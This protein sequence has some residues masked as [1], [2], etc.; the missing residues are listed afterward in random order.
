MKLTCNS[1]MIAHWGAQFLPDKE[2]E[3]MGTEL[4]EV[5]FLSDHDRYWELNSLL[6]KDSEKWRKFL[7]SKTDI[8][9]DSDYIKEQEINWRKNGEVYLSEQRKLEVKLQLPF[10]IVKSEDRGTNY[11]F[12][13]STNEE[14]FQYVDAN[15]KSVVDKKP[16]GEPAFSPE[17]TI[18][19]IDD[20]FDYTQ[21]RRDK[22]LEE[23]LK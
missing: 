5:R 13:T 22:K 3:V 19:R 10:L 11:K 17:V 8:E 1:P 15:G 14:I 4:G 16:N 9:L 12:L 21:I 2:Y 7:I 6:L 23:L 18:R 20:F